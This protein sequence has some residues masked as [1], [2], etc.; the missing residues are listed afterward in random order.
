MALQ[1]LYAG[2]R[3][4]DSNVAYH[5][6]VGL[7]VNAKDKVISFEVAIYKDSTESTNDS[8]VMAQRTFSI[9]EGDFNTFVTQVMPQDTWKN[10]TIKALY[11][12]VKAN[13]T[14]YSNAI[15]V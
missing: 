15:D 6:I 14:Y 8:G 3:G 11:T 1:K 5:R 10:N 7:S 9:T 4:F 12:W 2:E 13:D